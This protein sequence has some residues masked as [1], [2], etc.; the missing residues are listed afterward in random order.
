MSAAKSKWAAVFWAAYM[1]AL[2]A[3]GLMAKK[4]AAAAEPVR[5]GD[6]ATYTDAA[7]NKYC[8]TVAAIDLGAAS[9]ARAWVLLDG[10]PP[11]VA[12]AAP[13]SDLIRG[14]AL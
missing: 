10:R 9:V 12:Q 8:G 7:G 14:C 2:M 4:C 3:A 13:L 6:R 1:V 11:H 5:T